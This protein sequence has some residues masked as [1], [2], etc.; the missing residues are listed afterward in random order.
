[1]ADA[2]RY[3]RFTAPAQWA[4]EFRTELKRVM[5]Q[6]IVFRAE[7]LFHSNQIEY[8]AASEHFRPVVPGE[9]IPEYRWVFSDTDGLR[10]EEVDAYGVDS[11]DG[12]QR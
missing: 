1:M 5:G 12:G 6:C 3:G 4:H 8:F 9:V 11:V 2:R 7:H 10:A